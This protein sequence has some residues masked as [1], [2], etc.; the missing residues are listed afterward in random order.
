MVS[1]SINDNTMQLCASHSGE[2][3]LGA[4]TWPCG[5]RAGGRGSRTFGEGCAEQLEGPWRAVRKVDDAGLD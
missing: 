1:Q 3:P 4:G 5:G 2:G